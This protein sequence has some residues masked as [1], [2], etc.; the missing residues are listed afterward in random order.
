VRQT[1]TATAGQ[2]TFTITG[3]YDAGFADVYLNGVK[4]VNG[5]DVN[6][7]SGTN[8]VLTV[9]AAAGDSVDVIAYG[10]FVL[11]NTYTIAQADAQFLTKNNPSYTGTLTGGTGVINIGS[12]QLYKDAS[13]NV[14]IGTSSP[15][16]KLTLGG[17][18]SDV[19]FGMRTNASGGLSTDGFDITYTTSNNLYFTNRESGLFSFESGGSERMRIDSSGNLLVGTTTS[20]ARIVCVTTSGNAARFYNNY[21]GVGA[22][23][24]LFDKQDNNTTT[25]NVFIQFTI[26]SQT[27][28]SGQINANGA[29]SAAFGS[30]SD[31]RLKENIQ[32]LPSQ[33]D[34]IMALRPVEF[35][36]IESE[37]GGHQ[38]GFIAQEMQEVYPD[39]VGERAPDGMLTIT[40]WSK[41]EARLIKAIQ[42]QQAMIA[43]QS[44]IIEQL[45]ARVEALEGAAE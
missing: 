7:T 40:G 32:D 18:A 36:Y 19:S 8:V 1:F 3:G 29:N 17:G 13:G 22:P 42:E 33:L 28:G 27:V 25:S 6:V 10:A 31:R 9:G 12:G 35:D 30:F 37:G 23:T 21:S 24:V 43:S 4:L 39:A 38:I 5:V 16:N 26:N 14:G 11:A 2:T 44:E 41:T 34:N 20:Q 45:K 15:V